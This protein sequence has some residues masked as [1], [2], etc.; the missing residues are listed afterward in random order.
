MADDKISALTAVVTPAI[1]DEFAVNQSGTAK[2]MSL[3]QIKAMSPTAPTFVAAGAEF[4]S[5][6]VPTAILPT[7]HTTNDILVLIL[8]SSNDS[9]VA[10]PA[11]YTQVGPQN[12]LGIAASAGANRMSVFWKRD[13]GSEA[14]PT[15]P[16]TG[17]HT[18]GMM[19]A[20][21]GCP[22]TGDPF[23]FGGNSFKFTTSTSGTSPASVTGI[24]NMLV[25]DMW[26]GSA[27]NA[28]AEG[29]SYAN[30]DLSSVTEQFDDGTTDGT[31]GF[32]YVGTGLKAVAGP[33][34][35]STV[36]WAN[37]SS[38]LCIR[39]HFVPSEA[40]AETFSARA[41]Q[42]MVFIGSAQD[43]DDTWIKP[44]GARNVKVQLCDG[45]GSGSGGNITTTAAGGGGGGGGGYDEGF[46][47]ADTYG[48]TVTVHAG[49]GGAV[50]TALNQAG[51]AGV[52]SEWD[53]GG[54]GPLTT[55]YRIAGT[56][57]TAAASADGG[58]GGCGSGRG[59]VSPAVAATRITLEGVVAGAALGWR[60]GAG[61]SGTTAPT[62]GSPAESGGGGG[63]SGGDTD[64]ASTSLLNGYSLRGGGGG[65]SGRT[66][67]NISGSGA[68][69]G[70]AGVISAQGA[71]GIDS[72]RLPYGGSGGVGGGSSVVTGGA[73][74]FPGGGGGGGAG[75]AGGFG[76]R[77]GHGCV[78]VTTYF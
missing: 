50:G 64:A 71:V 8:Q 77:G 6:G 65:S 75:V 23:T 68:G 4:T 56:A 49:K 60:G 16:D 47:D 69:G 66:N 13:G 57:A 43:T 27:D 76:G 7:G 20:I 25:V 38:D 67:A 72:T 35:A 3:A 46:F 17:D 59:T 55:A 62:S 29:S 11:G 78:V 37:T 58:N 54:I 30:T 21:R 39:L 73:G 48:A 44:T 18:Y 26:T 74:G 22:T 5:T 45:G 19:Y 70:A 63:E 28:S 9:L 24:D 14:A 15:I 52:I 42:T 61:G 2:K 31:G 40:N 33:V 32:I 36:T 10:A 51:N 53:K 41:T 12:G 1:T 34:K